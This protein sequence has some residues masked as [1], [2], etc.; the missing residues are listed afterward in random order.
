[1]QAI[2]ASAMHRLTG[3]SL[4]SILGLLWA[5]SLLEVDRLSLKTAAE[6]ELS[7]RGRK[8]DNSKPRHS[9]SGHVSTVEL[10]DFA[11]GIPQLVLQ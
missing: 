8:L 11:S 6:E 2:A 10:C 9:R 1:M 3:A 7:S 5:F 4:E